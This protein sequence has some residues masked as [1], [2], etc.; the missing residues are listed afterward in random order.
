MPTA[1][2]FLAVAAAAVALAA[3][4]FVADAPLATAGPQTLLVNTT[5]D[6]FDA[7]CDETHCSLRDA[8]AAA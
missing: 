1:R 6:T 5:T 7:V 3:S 4:T 8:I 2:T